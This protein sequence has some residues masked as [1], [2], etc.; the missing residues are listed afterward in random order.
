MKST[1]KIYIKG[2]FMLHLLNIF[3]KYLFLHMCPKITIIVLEMYI[4]IKSD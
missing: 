2:I 4:H 1:Y 3:R